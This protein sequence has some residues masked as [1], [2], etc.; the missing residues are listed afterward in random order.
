MPAGTFGG[1]HAWLRPLRC[2]GTP[3]SLGNHNERIDH[4]R[5]GRG[6]DDGVEVDLELERPVGQGEEPLRSLEPLEE[7]AHRAGPASG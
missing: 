2:R 7:Q 5:P 6:G 3:E 1:D 4:R